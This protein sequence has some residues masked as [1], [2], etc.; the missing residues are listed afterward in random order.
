MA[1]LTAKTLDL[2]EKVTGMPPFSVWI[3]V[4]ALGVEEFEA[5]EAGDTAQELAIAEEIA[6]LLAPYIGPSPTPAPAPTP[7]PAGN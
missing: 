7:T 4:A 1:K 3:Q 2:A 6:A 5:F